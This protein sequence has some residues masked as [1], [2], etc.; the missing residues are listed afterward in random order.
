VFI[1]NSDIINKMLK[2][3]MQSFLR[4]VYEEVKR[5]VAKT[6]G[7]GCEH[8]IDLLTRKEA[9]EYLKISLSTLDKMTKSDQ[10]PFY[11]I[12][13]SIKYIKTE[14]NEFLKSKRNVY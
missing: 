8:Q 3:E 4:E 7:I 14:I 1:S 12:G 5:E 6:A 11:K 10:I 9:A 13:D 2:E